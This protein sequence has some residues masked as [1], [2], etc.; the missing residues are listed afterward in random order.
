MASKRLRGYTLCLEFFENGATNCTEISRQT[1]VHE[2]TVRRYLRACIS[3]KPMN[4]IGREGRP[5]KVD[6][7]GKIRI[8]QIVRHNPALSSEVIANKVNST[9]DNPISARTLQ[10]EVYLKETTEC[11]ETRA[12]AHKSPTGIRPYQCE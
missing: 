1:K 11:S 5:P 7:P 8:A 3:K 2:R 9:M 4:E 12:P 6:H 10:H